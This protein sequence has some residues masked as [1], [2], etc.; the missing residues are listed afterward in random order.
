MATKKQETMVLVAVKG[1]T[2][3]SIKEGLPGVL[4]ME[5]KKLKKEPQ[6]RGYYFQLRNKEAF[7]AQ[8]L[9]PKGKKL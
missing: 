1:T 6:W 3:K 7:L 4:T 8:P 9:Y 5:G 2:A